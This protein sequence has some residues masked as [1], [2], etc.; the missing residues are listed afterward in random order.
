MTD[1]VREATRSDRVDIIN[2]IVSL[3]FTDA[4]NHHLYEEFAHADTNT[5]RRQLLTLR[6]LK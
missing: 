1:L 6:L 3:V 2:D 4:A 5:H